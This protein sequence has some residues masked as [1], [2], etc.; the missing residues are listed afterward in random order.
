G[1]PRVVPRGDP[2]LHRL[3]PDIH[4]AVLIT[5]LY[6][7]DLEGGVHT[8]RVD[9]LLALLLLEVQSD[10][11]VVRMAGILRSLGRGE[12]GRVTTAGSTIATLPAVRG[13]LGR[14]VALVVLLRFLRR[15]FGDRKS[16]V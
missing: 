6:D 10:P 9:L 13:F 7:H 8:G 14:F 15:G 3:R 1:E 11:D 5:A 4:G 12:V 16:V 2:Q